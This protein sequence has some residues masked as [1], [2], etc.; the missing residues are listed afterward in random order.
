MPTAT[1]P[2]GE[3]LELKDGQ[4]VP[5]ES[6]P[7]ALPRMP[8]A[9]AAEED[10]MI[11]EGM[12]SMAGTVAANV[13]SLPHAAGELLAMGAAVPQTAVGAAGAAIGGTPIDLIERFSAAR[14]E[15]EGKFPARALLALPDPS[16]EDVLAVPGTVPRLLAS[17]SNAEYS[18]DPNAPILAGSGIRKA[19]GESLAAEQARAEENPL[20]HSAGRTAGDVASLLLLRPGERAARALKLERMNPRAKVDVPDASVF[21]KEMLDAASRAL[22]R[23]LGRTAEAG[24]EGAVMAAIGDG[25]PAKTAAWSA[26]VQAGSSMA[27][28][29]KSTIMRNPIKSAVGIYFGHEIWKVIAPGPQDFFG[30]KDAAFQEVVGAYAVG[31][32]A[33]LAGGGRGGV[34]S[35]RVKQVT[36]VLNDASRHSIQSVLAQ[37]NEG[38]KRGDTK[39]ETVIGKIAEDP[40]YFGKDFRVRLER[41]SRSDKPNALLDEIDSL[42]RS[43]RFR[44]KFAAL[45]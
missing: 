1:G 36:S 13:L 3:K 23:G 16:T 10:R 25:D 4:W 18:R 22:S 31:T 41:A 32:L 21:S 44:Q 20:A 45:E 2:N 30:S 17:A 28:S 5:M 38:R 34:G 6:G 29:A 7:R 27:L 42:M 24:F 40:D 8:T 26:G 33:G 43:N 39:Y 19:F 14:T 37:I 35:G 9:G 15:Q 12:R 11:R